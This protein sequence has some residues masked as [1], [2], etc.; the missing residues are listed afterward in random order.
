MMK[1]KT[2]PNAQPLRF[3]QKLWKIVND[4]QSGAVSWSPHGKSILLRYS[5]F[6]EEFM[7][8][9][10][11]FFKTENISSFV[12]QLNLYG[13]RKVYDHTHK[14]SYKA[15]RELHEFSN[16]YFQRDRCHLLDKV[17]RKSGVLNDRNYFLSGSHRSM[18]LANNSCREK[19][20]DE[21]NIVEDNVYGQQIENDEGGQSLQEET[22]EGQEVKD[23]E[24]QQA[25]D[26]PQT[27]QS[28]YPSQVLPSA[29]VIRSEPMKKKR[30]RKHESK[31]D[32]NKPKL[33]RFSKLKLKQ[34]CVPTLK[35]DLFPNLIHYDDED[36]SC[37]LRST[38]PDVILSSTL[39]FQESPEFLELKDTYHRLYEPR[40]R[41]KYP[42][43]PF[44]ILYHGKA[45]Y[46]SKQRNRSLRI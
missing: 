39:P 8:P 17:T 28:P 18:E 21:I 42:L 6:K 13:F 16:I 31:R 32:P 26:A 15:N 45:P 5:L 11:Y 22:S 20:F 40:I 24:T 2:P 35:A 43:R 25:A 30:G 27:E 10:N 7:S 9:K 38:S 29:A 33:F 12:R 36:T 41:Q 3:P 14:Q 46:D 4:C 34:L 37:F 23:S 19:K 44:S 1:P